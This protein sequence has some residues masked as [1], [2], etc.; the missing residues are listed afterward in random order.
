MPPGMESHAQSD[1][2]TPPGYSAEGVEVGM[3]TSEVCR[4]MDTVA[5]KI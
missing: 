3:A 5:I 2:G 4:V 1:Y